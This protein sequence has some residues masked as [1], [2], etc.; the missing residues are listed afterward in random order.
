MHLAPKQILVNA[1]I[2][3]RNDLATD[4]IEHTI[5]EVEGLIKQ[6]E[7]KV[8]MI[9]LETARE[10]EPGADVPNPQHIG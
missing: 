8:D 6:A 10:N 9:F 4:D 5:H 2:N 1:H 7:P 3:F